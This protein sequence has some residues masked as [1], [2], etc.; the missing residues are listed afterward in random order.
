MV[1]RVTQQSIYG[2]VVRQSNSSLSNL[3]ATNLQSSTQKRINAPSDDPTGSVQVL[4]TRSTLSQLSRYQSNIKLA[5]GWLSQGDSTLSSVS[6]LIT[7]IKTLAEQASSGTVS[8]ENRKEI[9]AQVRE[10][11]EQLVTLANTQFNGNYIFSGQK[12]DT[13]SYVES[14]WMTSNDTAFDAAVASGGG[15]TITGDSAS[16][17]LVQFLEDGAGANQPSFQYSSDGGDTWTTGTYATASGAGT[18]VLSLGSG[19]TISMASS[20]LHAVTGSTDSEDSNGTWMWIRPTAIYQGNDNSTVN[21]VSTGSSSSGVVASAGGTFTSNVMVR[22]DS[23]CDFSSNASF[24]YSYSTDGG[25]SWVPATTTADGHSLALSLPGGILTLETSGGTVAAGDQFFVQPSTANISVSISPSDS[26]VV[27]SVGSEIFGGISHGEVVTFNGS[28]SANLME[29]V[30]KLVGYLETNNEDGISSCLDDL[31]TSQSRVLDAES[32]LGAR[33]N[34]VDTA[35]AF[36]EMLTG[37]ANTT[38][39]N[40]E[41]ADLTSLITTLAEQEL[42]YQAV[43]KSSST[44]MGLSLMNYI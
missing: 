12:T 8:Q 35:D 40:V 19:L 34:R 38:L 22:A 1:M 23:D 20:A 25:S 9:S 14:L 5:D 33:V 15:F 41:D 13:S 2:T 31:T 17:V 43:L 6:T 18:Q 30:G 16:T 27:N 10:Y 11:F 7:S 36:V 39:S 3:I 29:T 42:A 21:V 24:K 32:S 28:A 44:V 4:D 37:T 26:V